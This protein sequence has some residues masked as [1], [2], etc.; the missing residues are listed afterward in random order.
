MTVAPKPT[1]P[2]NDD[3]AILRTEIDRLDQVMHTALMARGEIIERLIEVKKKQGGGSAFR[4]DR[5]VA[6]MR[7]L[8]GRHKGLLPVDTVESI[9]R[10]IIS[11]F[12]YVQANYSAHV[13]VSSGDAGMRDSAR[14]HFG[15]TVPFVPHQGPAAVI[16]C[17]RETTTQTSDLCARS[18]SPLTARGGV[19]SK[20]AMRPKSSRACPSSSAWTIP[21]ARPSSSSRIRW[22]RRRRK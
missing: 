12:T 15:F 3:L 18:A 10:V 1:A 8:V 21:P 11:T 17:G 16:R 4:P 22:R 7:T 9:W 13:D 14:F 20:P 2:A 6:M 5:E 19:R